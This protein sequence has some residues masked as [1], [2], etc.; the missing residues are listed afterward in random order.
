MIKIKEKSI[1]WRKGMTVTDLLKD[2]D[3]PQ[4]YAVVKINNKYISRTDFKKTMIPD[5]SEIFLI[6]MVAGG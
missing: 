2:L 4:H 6:P 1:Q 5:N 3:D